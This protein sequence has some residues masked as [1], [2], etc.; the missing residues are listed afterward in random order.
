MWKVHLSR[1]INRYLLGGRPKQMISSRCYSEHHPRAERFINSL[2]WWQDNHCKRTFLWEVRHEASN[3]RAA[4][5]KEEA[6]DS[7]QTDPAT[8]ET[9][10]A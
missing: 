2:F 10:T 5:C 9:E 1:F 3:K 8:M 4:C 6:S 7:E